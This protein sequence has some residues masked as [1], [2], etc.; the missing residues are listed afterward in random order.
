[1]TRATEAHTPEGQATVTNT[2]V[3]VY[4]PMELK[5]WLRIHAATLETDM[6]TWV[7]GLIREARAKAAGGP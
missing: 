3:N 1:M 5:R 7:C 4:M 2:Y 6:S